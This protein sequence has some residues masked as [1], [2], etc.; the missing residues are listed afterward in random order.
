MMKLYFSPGTIAS[1]SAIALVGASN[2]TTSVLDYTV[3]HDPAL[4]APEALVWM[5]PGGYTENQNRISQNLDVLS[6]LPLLWLFP[7]MWLF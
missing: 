1:A 5:S 3:G 6:T 7:T 4:P 2:G